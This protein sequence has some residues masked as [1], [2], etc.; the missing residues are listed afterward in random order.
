MKT[1]PLKIHF[2]NHPIHIGV[3]LLPKLPDLLAKESVSRKL[4]I[5]T[6]PELVALAQPMMDALVEAEY[7]V[8]IHTIPS[9]E[10]SKSMETVMNLVNSFLE[11]KLERRDT[12]IAFGGG[13]V[14]DT[15]GF[16]ASVYLRGVNLIQVPTT[17]LA[18]V[19]SAIGG[20]TGV[21]HPSGKNLIGTFCQPLFT[22]VDQSVLG[23]LPPR[24]IKSGLAEIIKYGVIGNA[25][26]FKYLESHFERVAQYDVVSHPD[27]WGH[28]ITR[29]ASDKAKVVSSDEKESG[30][31]EIL[32]FGHTIGHGIENAFNYGTYLH[33]EAVAIGMIGAT[34]LGEALKLTDSKTA[35]RIEKLIGDLGFDVTLRSTVTPAQIMAAM[36]LDK[37]V[38][39]GKMRFVLPFGIGDV[40]TV[41]DIPSETVQDVVE[42][43]FL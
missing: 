17:L 38:R 11:H 41:A 1:I 10:S 20:K 9:G 21:N 25:G 43:L 14:G 24:E 22:L 28:L 29:S 36:Q 4:A 26:L 33:G 31:R 7:L 30:L 16:A 34:R 5:V 27:L 40:E 42:G 19:D 2:Q 3:N 15:A 32:N 6:H 18:Q 23:S 8:S 12:V 13:V 35:M 39:D 37:K